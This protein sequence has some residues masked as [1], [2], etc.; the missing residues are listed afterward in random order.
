VK[1]LEKLTR[2][3]VLIL[4]VNQLVDVKELKKLT[5]LKT[6]RLQGNP[7]LTKAHIAEL[8]K[9]LPKCNI[10]SNARK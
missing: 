10:S 4:A 6:L 2:L 8:K 1:G 5:Q 3:E 9:A 7:D